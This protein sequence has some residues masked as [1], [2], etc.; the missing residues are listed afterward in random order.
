MGRG[1]G[2]RLVG[3]LDLLAEGVEAGAFGG[4]ILAGPD[5]E[6]LSDRVGRVKAHDAGG[7]D[8]PAEGDVTAQPPGH[9]TLEKQILALV[10][11]YHLCHIASTVW[12]S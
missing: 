5:H 10:K 7:G 6:V 3:C 2:A 4:A 11:S 1:G 8:D 9:L 12:S